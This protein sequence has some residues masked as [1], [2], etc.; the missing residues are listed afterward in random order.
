[1][2]KFTLLFFLAVLLLSQSSGQT[3]RRPVAAAYIGLGAYSLDHVDVFSF[4]ANQA[5]LAQL[6]NGAGGI[7]AE[8]RFLLAELNNYICCICFA[9]EFRKFRIESWLFWFQRL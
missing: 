7:Y 6:K 9:D 4:T 1:M 5:S 3:L 8:R 2:R